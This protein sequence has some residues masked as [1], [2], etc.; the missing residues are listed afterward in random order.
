MRLLQVPLAAEYHGEVLAVARTQALR[1][2]E[3][4]LE[5]DSNPPPILL[6]RAQELERKVDQP[7]NVAI[8]KTYEIGG[9]SDAHLPHREPIRFSGKVVVE[10]LDNEALFFAV[11]AEG[12][13]IDYRRCIGGT[14]LLFEAQMIHW[15]TQPFQVDQPRHIAFYGFDET[16]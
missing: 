14:A 1:K 6:H 11:P 4:A 15:V 13:P 2:V 9:Q 12:G 3:Y 5:T 10:S 7:F 16:A 8:L